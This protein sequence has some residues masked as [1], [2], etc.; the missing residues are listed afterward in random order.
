MNPLEFFLH[1]AGKPVVIEANPNDVLRDVLAR[2]D[3]LPRDGEFV[4]IGEVRHA[5]E[6]PEGAEDGHAAVDLTLTLLMLD[7]P[8]HRHIHTRAVHS[9]AVTVDF[10]GQ[11]PHR[12]FG[13]HAK[14]ETV[15]TWAKHRLHI[16]PV[17]GAEL[18]LE[19]VPGGEVPR[20]SEYLSDLA[21]GKKELTFKLVKEVNPQGDE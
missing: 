2:H 6:D 5:L 11:T 4:F 20:M 9:I 18:V 13:P 16:D 8:I 7:L 17:A 10:N 21:H 19:M 3:A 15:L 1:G 14:V 12:K